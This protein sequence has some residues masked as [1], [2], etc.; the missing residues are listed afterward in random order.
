MEAL[1]RSTRTT[2]KVYYGETLSPSYPENPPQNLFEQRIAF[3]NNQSFPSSSFS[4]IDDALVYSLFSSKRR[5]NGYRA[6]IPDRAFR[7]EEPPITKEQ[8]IMIRHIYK[9]Y[10]GEQGSGLKENIEAACNSMVKALP[11]VFT[12]EKLP[13]IQQ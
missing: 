10:V 3:L 13:I 6:M 1:R 2:L 5:T 8:G 11:N 4:L 9:D 7:E 12:M